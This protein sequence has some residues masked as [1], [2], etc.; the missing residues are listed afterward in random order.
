[1]E[2]ETPSH[3]DLAV[4]LFQSEKADASSL[5]DVRD[6]A[7]RTFG[8]L[9]THLSSRLGSDGYQAL[10]KRALMLSVADCAWLASIRV[11]EDGALEETGQAFVDRSVNELTDGY[12]AVMANLIGLLDTF[13]G[14][15]LSLRVL[16]SVWPDW[17]WN[18]VKGTQGDSNG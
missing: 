9:N 13:I 2:Q 6:A 7:R 18:D 4:R 16:H 11:A 10:L 8:K 1:M 17:A 3:K 5:A 12:V 15:K 14:R